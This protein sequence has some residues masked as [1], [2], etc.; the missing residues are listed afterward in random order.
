MVG[1]TWR[2]SSKINGRAR[3]GYQYKT[4]DEGERSKFTG[5]TVDLGINWIPKQRAIYSVNLS[6]VAEDSDT[7]GDYINNLTGSLG[8]QH[9]WTNKVD[10]NIQFA[11]SNKDYIG[12]DREDKTTNINAELIYGVSRWLNLLA[13]YEY[14]ESSSSAANIGYDQNIFTLSLK[15]GL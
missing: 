11:Y 1:L 5:N 2:G 4:F 3:F 8:W 6:R 14:S 12:A 15:A 10:S 7:V 13:G 9:Q